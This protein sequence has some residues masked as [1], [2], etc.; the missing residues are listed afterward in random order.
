MARKEVVLLI[1]LVFSCAVG[2][3]C[4]D[5]TCDAGETPESCSMDCYERINIVGETANKGTFDPS[6]EYSGDDGWLIYSGL[7]SPE[8]V[9][10]H[11]QKYTSTHL[12]KSVDAGKTW[13]FQKVINPS[14][15][16][17]V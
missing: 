12:A 1:L 3:E 17:Q 13:T 9:E 16:A 7:H 11:M 4:G 15:D 14:I 8:K 10:E 2:G 6:V 5:G